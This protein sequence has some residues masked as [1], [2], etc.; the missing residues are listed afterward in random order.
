MTWGECESDE[1]EALISPG[2]ISITKKGVAD[3]VCVDRADVLWKEDA[4]MSL[5]FRGNG[6]TQNSERA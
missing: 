5:D 6:N 2:L 3:H 1:K 4:L